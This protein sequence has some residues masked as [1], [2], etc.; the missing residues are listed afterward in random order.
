MQGLADGYFVLPPMV[1]DY[2]AQGGLA[3]HDTGH[4]A[5]RE[6]EAS[7]N[8][9][10]QKLLAIKGRRTVMELH[11]ELG[12]LLWNYCGMARNK[13]GLEHAL[14]VIP[15]LR[16]QFWEDVNV[17]GSNGNINQALEHANRLADFL[18][19][20]ELMVLD[21]L[22]RDESCGAHFRE[23]HQTAEGEA[24]RNDAEYSYVSVWEFT[25]VGKRPNLH[26]EP[27][28]FEEVHLA[29]RSYK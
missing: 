26:K 27:L 14:T 6:A 7:V 11:R 23:E 13:A 22:D 25:G 29:E 24:K 17:P 5:F 28:E 20:A 21:A 4:D 9:K 15:Q 18:E 19:F 12:K 1:S 16:E 10:T 2:I 3:R 8:E